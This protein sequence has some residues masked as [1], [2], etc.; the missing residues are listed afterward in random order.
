[1]DAAG[2]PPKVASVLMGHA[3]PDRQ[4]GAADIT[5][6]RYTHAL[7]GYLEDAREK[8]DEFV[9]EREKRRGG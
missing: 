3:V 8:L 4:A 9:A 2:V 5:L 1:M 6:Q 7:P